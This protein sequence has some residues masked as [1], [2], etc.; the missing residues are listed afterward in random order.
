V[1]RAVGAQ[2]NRLLD[3]ALEL[4]PEQRLS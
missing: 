2:L 3:E 4:A 1:D